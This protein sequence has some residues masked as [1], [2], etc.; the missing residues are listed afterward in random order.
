MDTGVAESR[1]QEKDAIARASGQPKG[2]GRAR[3]A[4]ELLAGLYRPGQVLELRE[5]GERYEM[6]EAWLLQAFGDLE[7]L[8]LLTPAGNHPATVL[9]PSRKE[10]MEV[11]ELRA[12]LEER[13]GQTAATFLEGGAAELQGQVDA[14]LAAV[15]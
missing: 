4:R 12:G 10:V 13:A 8:G 11:Y 1:L 14:M 7:S 3:L 6:D 9:S 15:H 2:R 5:V